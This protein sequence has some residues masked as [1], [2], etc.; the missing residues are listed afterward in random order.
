LDLE[1]DSIGLLITQWA[2]GMGS[3]QAGQPIV[4]DQESLL[5]QYWRLRGEQYPWCPHFVTSMINYYRAKLKEEN[6][7]RG[8]A[9]ADPSGQ[10]DR[11]QST[12]Y[13]HLDQ[14]DSR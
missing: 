14:T 5:D 13:L 7:A 1:W 6:G 12:Y 2:D 3:S 10:M 4:K 8:M 11:S 9:D